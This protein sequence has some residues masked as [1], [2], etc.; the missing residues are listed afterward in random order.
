M[1]DQL[2]DG[3]RKFQREAFPRF[4]ERYRHL[5]DEGQKPGTL[6]I[7]CA[8]SRVV[9][10][11]LLS[12]GPGE[13]FILRNVGNLVPPFEGDS[14]YHGTSAGIEFA[15]L[16]LGVRDIVVCG[17]THCGAIRALYAASDARTPHINA[18]LGLA[19]DAMVPV[20]D[21]EPSREELHATEERSIV[22]QLSRLLSY[23]MVR[24]RVESGV[25]RL[26]AWHYV[27]EDGKVLLWSIETGA[28]EPLE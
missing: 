19:R 17:H 27:I 13:L 4:Q 28:F 22:L 3:L 26:H 5:V 23:P 2:F 1:T 18:W 7:G 6:F 14:G 11:T 9:P 12:A 15:V 10:E 20:A 21:A 16:Q 24:E 8:D 25:I